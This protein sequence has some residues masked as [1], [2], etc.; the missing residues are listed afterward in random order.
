MIRKAMQHRGVLFAVLAILAFFSAQ[1][2]VTTAQQQERFPARGVGASEESLHS[3]FGTYWE[4]KLATQPELATRVGRT[5]FND[6]WRDLSKRARDLARERRKEFLQELIYINTGN[7]TSSDRLSANVLQWELKNARDME[8]Y[9]DLVT[10]VSQQ[11]GLH[12][13]VFS[14]IDQMPARTL[15]DYDNI[16]ARLNAIPVF[17]DQYIALLREQIAARTTQPPVV[18]DLVLAQVAAQGRMLAAE[19][20]L[21]AAFRQFPGEI[22]AVD[23]KRLL[24]A[25]TTAYEQKFVPS[26]TRLETFLRGTYR[27]SARTRIAVTSMPGGRALY[28]AAVRFHTTTSMTPEQIHRLGLNEVA[29]IEQEMEKVARADGFTGP[30]S[31]YEAHLGNRSGMRFSSQQEMVDY[32]RD[33]LARVQP[34]LPKLFKRLPKMSLSIRPIPPDREASTASNYEAGT[35]DGSRPAWF[36]INTY[37]PQQ[38]FKYDIEALVLHE[39]VPGHHLQTAIAR[40]VEDLPEFR[41]VFTTTA[42]GEGW[43][44]YAESLGSE[45]GVVYR[46]PPS[47]LGQLANEQFRAVRLV[48][49]TGMHVMGWSRDR[50][51]AYFTMHVP[52]QSLAEIDRYIA[53]PGQAL[54]YKVGQ[55][56][57]QE[58]RLRAQKELGPRFDVRDFHDVVLRNGRL[59]LDL[60]DEQVTA[61]I[62]GAR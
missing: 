19:T 57:I 1:A 26:W 7:L 18:V 56:K 55:L 31:E 35:A 34:T 22:R 51:R 47:R 53:W 4:W 43:A 50:A 21:L 3:L 32:A 20:P 2:R 12:T 10:G 17:I 41:R 59:P 42:F 23:Q 54:A 28:D 6:R 15:R 27:R 60:L 58:L 14:T 37:R 39:A 16:V 45:L 46:D 61:Y 40:E 36:N 62:T 52:A 25:A 11:S 48:V 13:D 9:T 5:E 38:Q 24:S 49:D 44:L 29:R 30:V 8:A 33:I